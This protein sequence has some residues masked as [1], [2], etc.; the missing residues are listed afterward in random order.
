MKKNFILLLI[1]IACIFIA[2]CVQDGISYCPYCGSAN[3]S[4]VESGVYKCGRTDCGKTF[5][6]KELTKEP[7]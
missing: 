4:E 6:A 1:I 2:A 7:K 3:I 5:G